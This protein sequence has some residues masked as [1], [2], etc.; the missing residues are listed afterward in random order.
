MHNILLSHTYEVYGDRL[1]SSPHYLSQNENAVLSYS[2]TQK[3]GFH[4]LHKRPLALSCARQYMVQIMASEKAMLVT[5]FIVPVARSLCLCSC[6]S[7]HRWYSEERSY[8]QITFYVG[9]WSTP[10]NCWHIMLAQEA[11]ILRYYCWVFFLNLSLS[12]RGTFS[13]SSWL[14]IAL[15][16]I[17]HWPQTHQT[18]F[19]SEFGY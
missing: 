13:H 19:F 10:W 5:A 6:W 14:D 18:R 3:N 17:R 12:M 4:T 15:P 8:L 11:D 2:T 9:N 16:Q 7:S 1:V